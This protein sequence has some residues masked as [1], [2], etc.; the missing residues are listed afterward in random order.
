MK[1]FSVFNLGLKFK[2]LALGIEA[3]INATRWRL[4]IV[5][6]SNQYS[7]YFK[8]YFGPLYLGFEWDFTLFN[9]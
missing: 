8:I 4:A 6:D 2:L 5:A 3:Y 7:K 9:D 1:N